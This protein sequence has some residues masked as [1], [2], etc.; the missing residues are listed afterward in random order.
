MKKA[1]LL[2]LFI[3]FGLVNL[4]AQDSTNKVFSWINI[5]SGI[6]FHSDYKSPVAGKI[7]WQTQIDNH[8]ITVYSGA[9][10]KGLSF[11]S[12][13]GILYGRILTPLDSKFMTAASLGYSHVSDSQPQFSLFG[14]PTGPTS[15]FQ[16]IGIPVQIN[17]Q[18]RFF[19]YLSIG[20]TVFANINDGSNFGG[21]T[22]GILLGKF[23]N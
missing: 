8:L 6:G 15:T 23:R 9:L 13:I 22:F 10:G 5:E 17:I 7:G 2:F 3:I 4:Q 16:G 19:K 1:K 14:G 11:Y 12:E 20:A 21:V 18:Y